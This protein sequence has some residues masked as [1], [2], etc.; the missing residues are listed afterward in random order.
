MTLV[1]K[2]L[3]RCTEIVFTADRCVIIVVGNLLL[4]NFHLPCNGTAD[5]IYVCEEVFNVIQ[6]NSI[7]HRNKVCII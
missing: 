4:V 2:S 6:T 7:D 5:R 3:K 1:K